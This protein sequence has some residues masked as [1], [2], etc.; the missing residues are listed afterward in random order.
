MSVDRFAI[1]RSNPHPTKAFRGEGRARKRAKSQI[2]ST[3]LQRSAKSQAPNADL[4]RAFWTLE[5]ELP[6]DLGFG[7]WDFRAMFSDHGLE[8]IGNY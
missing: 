4:Y 1:L 6:W 7:T 3:K 2:P 5:L 8:P